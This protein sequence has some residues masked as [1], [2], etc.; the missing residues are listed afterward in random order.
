MSRILILTASP[1]RD[2]VID[3]MISKHLT[4]M[5]HEVH[6]RPCLREGRQATLDLCPDVAVVPPIRNPY[7]RDMAEILK[8]FGCGVITRHTE[9]S[10]DWAD[11]KLMDQ[12]EKATI[13]GQFGYQV[14]AEIVWGPDE[15]EILNRRGADFKA[16]SI[17]S[18]AADVYKDPEFLNG[19]IPKEAFCQ[20]NKLDPIKKTILILTAWG[21]VDFSPDL[22]TDDLGKAEI[23]IQGRDAWLAMI[24]T[25]VEKYK[26]TYNVLVTLHPGVDPRPYHFELDPLGIFINEEARARDLVKHTDLIIHAGSTTALGAHFLG[27]PA[28]QYCDQNRKAISWW[29]KPKTVISRVS[30]FADSLDKLLEMIGSVTFGQTNANADAIKELES[31]RYGSMDGKATERA[32]EIISKVTGKFKWFWPDLNRDYNQPTLR[33]EYG[34]FVGKVFCNI[35]GREYFMMRPDYAAML[36]KMMDIPQGKLTPPHMACPWCGCNIARP[37]IPKAV[38]VS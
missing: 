29:D 25:V 14:N 1:K 32:A 4:A 35:C 26:D 20:A 3:E 13:I 2:L 5:G 31:G 34:D 28:L 36:E 22:H 12:Q 11:W 19:G 17:G 21:F 33:R 6:V 38:D 7:A 9:P 10:C 37:G 30:P 8:K 18:F 16:V 27:K 23:D 24:K 15:A